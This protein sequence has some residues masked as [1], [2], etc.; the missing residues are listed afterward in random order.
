MRRKARRG[1]SMRG[2]PRAAVVN[3]TATQKKKKMYE[4]TR[5]N[6]VRG[7]ISNGEE[8][9][10]K[11]GYAGS[12]NRHGSNGRTGSVHKV[13]RQQTNRYKQLERMN[14]TTGA[15]NAARPRG[16]NHNNSELLRCGAVG[17]VAL[18]RGTQR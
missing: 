14:Q 10:S 13:G 2:A 7:K 15:V 12:G 18:N 11:N 8:S 4:P 9:H 16:K 17:S 1:Y 5:R 3:C 6:G